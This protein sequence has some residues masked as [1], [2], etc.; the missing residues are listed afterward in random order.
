MDDDGLR[1]QLTR[2]AA[3]FPVRGRPLDLRR[4][5][6]RRRRIVSGLSVA[7][8]IV[9]AAGVAVLVLVVAGAGPGRGGIPLSG[10]GTDYV[11]GSWRLVSVEQGGTSTVISADIGARM[12]LLPDG[13]ILADDGVNAMSGRFT[14]TAAGFD[15]RDASTTLVGY[16][17]NDPQRLAAIAGLQNLMFRIGE[18]VAR[19]TVVSADGARL[20]VQAGT[21][22]LTFEWIG[23]ATAPPSAPPT[24]AGEP[25]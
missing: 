12:G 7:A 15:V 16:G 25:S 4:R 11:G 9:A 14:G 19:D 5:V 13:T 2:A 20:V 22:R 23:S 1:G 3:E 21:Y 6:V 24:T 10:A 18:N 8:G 17:G